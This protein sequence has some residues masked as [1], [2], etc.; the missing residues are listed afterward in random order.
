MLQI[1]VW[2]S[3]EYTLYFIRQKVCIVGR[4]VLTPL[5][6]EAPLYS[7]PPPPPHPFSNFVQP[8]PF[9]C[10]L[11]PPPPL[12]FLSLNGWSHHIWCA[13]L[14]NIMDLHMSS[15]GTLVPKEPWSVFYAKRRQVYWGLTHHV[16]FC[17]YSDLISNTHKDT[18][19]DTQHIQGPVDLHTHIYRYL[20]HLLWA[21]SN[22]LHYTEW[23]IYWYQ[24]ITF[25]DVFSFQRLFVKVI[26][27]LVRCYK[28]RFFK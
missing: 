1:I 3:G 5:F 16:V 7:L 20:Q 15:L 9:P 2:F 25:Y 10:H 6:Y 13:I 4:G 14:L 21:H 19:K 11:Q 26:Y 23:I 27:L 8:P 28:T 18:H 24:K 17:R 22:Y 12:L